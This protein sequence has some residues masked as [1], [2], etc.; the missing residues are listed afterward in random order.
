MEVQ[1]RFEINDK[2][3]SM[4]AN[5]PMEWK[6]Y[7]I[8]ETLTCKAAQ[9]KEYAEKRITYLSCSE[10]PKHPIPEELVFATKQEL[11]DSL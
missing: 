10:L 2:V 6:I 8:Q 7:R 5:A 11:L 9:A 1:R 3:W 4:Y